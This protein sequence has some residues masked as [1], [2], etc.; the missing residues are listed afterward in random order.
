MESRMDI[1][2]EN[3]SPKEIDKEED[4]KNFQNEI[5]SKK[6]DIE[7]EKNNCIIKNNNIII[8]KNILNLGPQN[9]IIFPRDYQ[10]QIFEKA[11][12]KNSIIY[13]DTGKG[14]TFISIMLMS[15]L[16]GIKLPVFEKPEIDNSK[17]IIFL[18][19]DTALI[20]QQKNTISLNLNLE[21]GTIQGKKNKKAK[22]D[23]TTFRKMWE[24]YNLF[25]AIPSIVYKLLSRGFLKISEINML[26]F[27]EC[28][29]A[30]ADH[31]YN[32]IMTEFYF[33]YKK[34][35]NKKDFKNIKLPIIIG[36][37]A[38]PLKSGIKGSI[39]ESAKNA[40]ETLSENLDCSF[41][42]DPDMIKEENID[43]NVSE[44]KEIFNEDNFIQVNSHYLADNYMELINIVY[45]F[46]D[47]M[48]KL[49]MKDLSK[50]DK[51]FNETD[52]E[53][54]EDYKNYLYSKF[55]SDN[56]NDYNIILE[57]NAYLYSLR[58][59]SPFFYIFEL[60]QRQIFM[61]I[62]NLCLDSLILFFN[63]LIEIYQELIFSN[64]NLDNIQ[65]TSYSLNSL[66][67]NEDDYLYDNSSFTLDELN[68]LNSLFMNIK[69]NLTKF[70]EGKNY[71][72]DKLVQMLKKI[73]EIYNFKNDSKIII[74]IGNRIV[75]YF[76]TPILSEYLLQKHPNIKCKEII[77]LNKRKTN[78]GT[79]LTQSTT[80]NEMN[81]TISDF[82]NNKINILIGTSAVEEG[83]DIQ[84]CNGVMVF[85][86]LMTVKSYIQ[87]KGRARVKD[88]KFYLFTNSVENTV[89]RIND[90]VE[91]RKKMKEFFKNDICKDFRRKKFIKLK[92]EIK[93]II[94]NKI[95]HAKLSLS[96]STE[97][98]NEIKQ[99]LL[100]NKLKLNYEI[101]IEK[102]KSN[103]IDIEFIGIL[104]IKETNLNIIKSAKGKEYKTKK[105]QSKTAVERDCHFHLLELLYDGNYLDEHFKLI[106]GK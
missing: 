13:L 81:K 60:V 54:I 40:M 25:V 23:L 62:N 52:N 73:D 102:V 69:Y 75:A 19:C 26:I 66:D 77:G 96:N 29:H 32:K 67:D 3:I 53:F 101:K 48:L 36:L 72:C 4:E 55:N 2:E 45:E 103:T 59:K 17:K 27:D 74:F 34:H 12:N 35:P 97:F 21:V 9:H 18:V 56:L 58:N 79:I 106:N 8:N 37:T 39:G 44:G 99:Q 65:N 95:S 43:K 94:F 41:V 100:N 47:E 105:M 82:N 1:E 64:S 57:A 11:K 7:K 88:S 90:F 83:L 89:K 78:K 80:L 92:E 33:F 68:Q 84:T 22:N 15:D 30:N 104:K 86:E 70:K 50:R 42:I 5:D 49:S 93:P 31:P 98:F 16:L 14:K 38:S 61:I 87:M 20:E 91:I 6:M 51:E 10:L 71:I 46:F 63:R 28:H 24:S 85:V 76:L